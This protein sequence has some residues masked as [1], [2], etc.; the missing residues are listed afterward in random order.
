MSK[1]YVQSHVMIYVLFYVFHF[2]KVNILLFCNGFN[3]Y[4]SLFFSF[5]IFL[6]TDSHYTGSTVTHLKTKD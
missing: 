6:K 1:F 2:P 4:F 3:F 5:N